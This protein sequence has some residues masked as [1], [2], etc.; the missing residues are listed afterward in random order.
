MYY[1]VFYEYLNRYN[2]TNMKY[3]GVYVNISIMYGQRDDPLSTPTATSIRD[4]EIT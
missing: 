2:V 4:F 3:N 1:Y